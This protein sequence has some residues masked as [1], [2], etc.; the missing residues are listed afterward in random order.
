MVTRF[1]RW[2]CICLV[3]AFFA[4]TAYAAE[5]LLTWDRSALE[6]ARE[7]IHAGDEALLPA[8]EALVRAADRALE[9]GPWTVTDKPFTPPSGDKRDYMSVGPF[10]WPNPDTEDGL[11]YIRRDGETN[12]ERHEYDNSTMGQM[13]N[14]V[15][16]LTLAWYF[17]GEERYAERA[18]KVL[19]VWF[20]DEDTGMNPHLEYGQAIPGRT[21]GRD[22]GII[23][24]VVLLTFMDE[25]VLLRGADAWSA[26]D[27]A[28]LQEWFSAYLRW[29]LESGHGKSE[30]SRVNNHGTWYDAQ[31]V[32]FALFT[33]EEDIARGVL[34]KVGERRIAV[35]IEPDGRQPREL[36]RTRAYSYTVYNLLAFVNLALMG[37]HVDVDVWNYE[38]EDGRSIRRALEWFSTYAASPDDLPHEQITAP[39]RSGA[40]W[41]YRVAADALGIAEWRDLAKAIGPPSPE[42]Y[43]NLIYL[44]D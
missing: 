20:L 8:Y 31:V 43:H 36:A 10:W 26:E 28:A 19:R 35:Q 40:W 33:G 7:R 21:E 9:D 11:P 16:S 27:D 1:F 5:P 17:T 12:P 24:T 34:E 6:T 42:H 22:I 2:H 13:R 29:L 37:R 3:A 23:D 14:A 38:S 44:P 32:A 25:L 15:R 4:G 41:L 30:G 18:A 39:N